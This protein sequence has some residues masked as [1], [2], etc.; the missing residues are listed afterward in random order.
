MDRE[1]IAFFEQI[2]AV[3]DETGLF[4]AFADYCRR[5]GFESVCYLQLV[6][7]GFRVPRHRVAAYH[8]FPEDWSNHYVAQGYYDDDPVM[9]A[10][11]KYAEPFDWFKVPETF[12]LTPKQQRFFA[13]VADA[14]FKSGYA[15]PVFGPAGSVAYFGLATMV[16]EVV[17]TPEAKRGLLSVC[18]QTHLGYLKLQDADTDTRDLSPREAEVMH[19]VALGKSNTAIAEILGIASATV[20]TLMRRIFDKLGVSNRTTAALKAHGSG[21]I[22]LEDSGDAAPRHAGA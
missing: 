12:D 5:H 10:A 19:W 9:A 6:K 22:L 2:S 8:N 16:A 4:E 17:M 18:H 3:Q 11:L 7:S 13:D 1:S 21:M 15:V 14:G 20:D